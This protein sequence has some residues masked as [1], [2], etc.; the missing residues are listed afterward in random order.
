MRVAEELPL[1]KLNHASSSDFQGRRGEVHDPW[2][3]AFGLGLREHPSAIGQV[4]VPCLDPQGLLRTATG[5]PCGDQQVPEVTIGD[6]GEEGLELS[7]TDDLFPLAALG[8]L[9]VGDGILVDVALLDRPLERT[10]DRPAVVAARA[11]R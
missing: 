3:A 8:L 5:L 10:L 4:D 7:G 11:T 2:C 1:G 6:E 9:K